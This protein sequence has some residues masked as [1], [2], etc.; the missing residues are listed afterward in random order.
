[1]GQGEEMT[2]KDATNKAVSLM[3]IVLRIKGVRKQKTGVPPRCWV[4]EGESV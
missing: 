1:M 3:A 4:M 2:S